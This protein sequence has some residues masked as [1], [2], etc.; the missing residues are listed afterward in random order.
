MSDS[1]LFITDV[2]FDLIKL[3]NLPMAHLHWDKLLP[4]IYR[5]KKGKIMSIT[6]AAEWYGGSANQHK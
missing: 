6:T 4:I 1:K 5:G 2:S 3:S